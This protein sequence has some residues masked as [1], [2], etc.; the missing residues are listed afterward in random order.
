MILKGRRLNRNEDFHIDLKSDRMKMHSLRY[1]Y[2]TEGPID[3]ICIKV[4]VDRKTDRLKIMIRVKDKVSVGL[5]FR[6]GKLEYV[7]TF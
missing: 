2:L 3:W 4:P 6:I 1:N 5:N 7:R